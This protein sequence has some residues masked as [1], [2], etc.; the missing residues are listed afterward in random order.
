MDSNTIATVVFNSTTTIG[1]S[2]G[3]DPVVS[4]RV[5]GLSIAAIIVGYISVLILSLGK[6]KDDFFNYT[7]YEKLL[8][9]YFVGGL[10]LSSVILL[11][12]I[13][14]PPLDILLKLPQNLSEIEILGVIFIS[15]ISSSILLYFST[16][17]PTRKINL[18]A[19]VKYSAINLIILLWIIFAVLFISLG[20]VG[21]VVALS[22]IEVSLKIQYVLLVVLTGISCY[23]NMKKNTLK[24]LVKTIDDIF[25]ND[26]Y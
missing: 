21:L 19:I 7:F 24:Q 20:I 9:S 1:N 18:K 23:L 17:A 4:Y 11:L 3:I 6:T 15:S 8:V 26:V 13:I 14:K 25:K 2:F 16:D 12:S 22:P 10:A 5:I